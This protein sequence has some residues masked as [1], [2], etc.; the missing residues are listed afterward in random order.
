[1]GRCTRDAS[2]AGAAR[3]PFAARADADAPARR[4]RGRVTWHLGRLWLGPPILVVGSPPYQG[5]VRG[6]F[7]MAREQPPL[8]PSLVRRGFTRPTP[9]RQGAGQNLRASGYFPLRNNE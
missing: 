9:Q 8:R 2:G 1:H 6:G 3:A 7:G 5:G 4:G